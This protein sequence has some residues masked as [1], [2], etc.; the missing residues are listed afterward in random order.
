MLAG[1][2]RAA[3]RAAQA[4]SE[5]AQEAHAAAQSVLAGLEAAAGGPA[6]ETD[7]APD[8]APLSEV[9]PAGA[10]ESLHEAVPFGGN[11]RF[12]ARVEPAEPSQ[13][14]GTEPPAAGE[15]NRRPVILDAAVAAEGY[16]SAQPAPAIRADEPFDDG[17]PA[18]PIYGNLIQFPREMVATRKVRPRRAEGPLAAAATGAQLSIFEVDPATISTQP[19]GPAETPAAPVW[20][21]A[22]LESVAV[23]PEPAEELL[24]E[25]QP[26]A[27][28]PAPE[29]L[30][31]MSRRL[32]AHV[33]DA[34]LIAAAFLGAAAVVGAHANALPG[35]RAAAL[36]S[37]LALLAIGAA[38]QI[39]FVILTGETPGMR[40]AGIGFS[41]FSGGRPSLAQRCARLMALA[42]SVLPLGLGVV[43]ALFDDDG[44]AWHDLLSGTYLRKR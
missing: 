39:L 4:A 35:P 44:L 29:E 9:H 16:E 7:A 43:W 18:Q 32:M 31:P 27:A 23:E 10:P 15:R 8:R 13:R 36:G 22:E 6:W 12:A 21:R 42:L 20:M 19:A 2:A 14:I 25:P 11:P 26:R 5:A 34:S 1:E 24:E 40:Y 17:D 28:T 33:V 37:A 41:T 3:M 30:A 38:Y